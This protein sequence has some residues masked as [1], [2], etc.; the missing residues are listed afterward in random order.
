MLVCWLGDNNTTEWTVRLKYVLFQKNSSLQS[1]IKC[2]PF[3]A[4]LGSGA[5]TGLSSFSLPPEILH[6]LQ[7]V[8]DL[9][10]AI[11]IS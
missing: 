10:A 11:A 8:D 9:F 4:L 6:R 3:T 1:R 2:S 7:S 5:R